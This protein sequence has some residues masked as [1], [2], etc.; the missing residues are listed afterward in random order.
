M[1][2]MEKIKQMTFS[3]KAM[4]L[5]GEGFLTTAALPRLDIPSIE[6]A[7]GPH[8]VRHA[9][10]KEEP[11]PIEGGCVCFP[12]ASAASATWNR[13]LL[14]KMGQGIARD[15]LVENFDVILGPGINIKRTPLCGRNF[16]YFSEDPIVAG[17]LGAAYINGV[18]SCGVA[19]SLKHFAANNQEIDRQKI[20]SEVDERTLREIYLRGFEIAVKKAKPMTIMNAYNKLN[21]IW[22]SENKWLQKDV[23]RDEWGFEGAVLSDWGAV[24]NIALALK[25][26]TNLQMPTNANIE[27]ELRFAMENGII[28]EEEIDEALLG[29]LNFL[30][31]VKAAP[32]DETPYDRNAQH[33]VAK[34]IADEAITLLKNE[35]DILPINPKKYEKI[36]IFGNFAKNPMYMG[37]GSSKVHTSPEFIETPYEFIEKHVAG[38]S[39]LSY[40]ELFDKK[41]IPDRGD[42]KVVSKKYAPQCDLAIVF[43]GRLFTEDTEDFDLYDLRLENYM[44]ECLTIISESCKNVVIVLQSGTAI[45]PGRWKDKAKGIVDMWLC[46]EAGGSAIVDVLFGKVNPS[47]KLSETFAYNL[48]PLLDYPGDG[49]K[50]TYPEQWKVGYRYF[51]LHPEQI[52]YPF[53]HGLSYTTFEYSDLKLSSDKVTNRDMGLTVSFKVKNTGNV[54]GKEAVQLYV[55][56]V[57][58]IISKP[59]KELKDFDKVYLEP[60]EEKEI[61]FHLD[62]RSLAYYNIC[63]HDWCVESGEYKVLIGASSRDIRLEQSFFVANKECYTIN[64]EKAWTYIAGE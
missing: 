36:G 55:S 18:Q 42:A 63:M 31:A 10:A 7:D 47:G 27:S 19:A 22:C 12:T 8:G 16:E 52:W 39:E 3:E 11:C 2:N 53:G 59:M 1:T 41:W 58:S 17:E 4:L 15:C 30:D 32:K 64:D 54:A 35:D 49:L 28:T 46:G 56:D 21:A 45:I 25:N 23:L 9:A 14:F 43:A 62:S 13:E 40:Y 51:D 60:G 61:V 44:D 34:E 57:E 24:H 48:N 38:E 29:L 20:S 37:G 26:G 50:V 5:T 6:M 33:K